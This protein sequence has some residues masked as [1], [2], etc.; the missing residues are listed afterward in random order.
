MIDDNKKYCIFCFQFLKLIKKMKKIVSIIIIFIESFKFKQKKLKI[1]IVFFNLLFSIS[2][3]FQRTFYIAR[4]GFRCNN[5]INFEIVSI[6]SWRV[7]IAIVFQI[8][9]MFRI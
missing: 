2:L 6:E 8:K 3:W 4:K 9:Y 5:C 1:E 7:V